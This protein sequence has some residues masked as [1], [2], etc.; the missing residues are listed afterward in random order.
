[1]IRINLI[2]VK[3]KKKP[4]PIPKFIFVLIVVMAASVVGTLLFYIN[5][6]TVISSLTAQKALNAN[7]MAELE[8][9]I[10][11]VRNFE[12]LNKLFTER[13]NIIE[14]LKRNQSLPVRVLDDLSSR[15]SDGVWFTALDIRAGEISLGGMAFTNSDV[16]KLV[17]SLK[18]SPIFTD[19]YLQETIQTKSDKVEVYSFKMTMK[20]KA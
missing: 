5:R 4:R 10:K 6:K 7:K 9:K 16:V 17:Q 3:R 15:L 8:D 14:E 12:S 18:D 20:I 11:E 1:M 19:V 13:K 2:P